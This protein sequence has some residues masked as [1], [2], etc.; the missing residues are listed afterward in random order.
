MISP[1]GDPLGLKADPVRPVPVVRPGSSMYLFSMDDGR[2]KLAYGQ[3][4]ED[5]LEI[6]GMRLT[7]DEMRRIVRNDF[8]RI[9]HGDLRKYVGRLG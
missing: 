2:K 5:A 6:L 8:I 4:P 9:H 3:S 1:D 7:P